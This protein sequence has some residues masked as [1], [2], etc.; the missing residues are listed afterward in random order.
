M[1]FITL[2]MASFVGAS[3]LALIMDKM[4]EGKK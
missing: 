1:T 2:A 3:S 4:V